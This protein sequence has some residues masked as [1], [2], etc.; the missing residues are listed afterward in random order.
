MKLEM[1]DLAACPAGWDMFQHV[2][3]SR[4][5][6]PAH[7]IC[8]VRL[9]AGSGEHAFKSWPGH[10]RAKSDPAGK[11]WQEIAAAKDVADL[12]PQAQ[13]LID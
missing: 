5:Q 10:L 6:G 7:T 13:H 1:A 9:R 4:S 2:P 8:M 3:A 11:D 12:Q